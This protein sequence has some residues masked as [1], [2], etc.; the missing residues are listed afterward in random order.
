L[1]EKKVKWLSNDE[2]III[3]NEKDI[4]LKVFAHPYEDFDKS[5]CKVYLDCFDIYNIEKQLEN[6]FFAIQQS[7]DFE[8][9][10]GAKVIDADKAI[11]SIGNFIISLYSIPKYF[12]DGD[13]IE[14]VV[15]RLDFD[16]ME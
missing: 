7:N 16:Y 5:F 13:Y 11:V 10:I 3:F 2:A 8:Y 4:Q 15:K 6:N 14:F 9:L 12:N 1:I